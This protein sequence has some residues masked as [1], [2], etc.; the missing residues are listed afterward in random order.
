MEKGTVKWF[1]Q[2]KG[3]GFIQRENGEDI[4]FHKSDIKEEGFRSLETG[5]SVQFTIFESPRGPKAGDVSKI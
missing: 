4:F 1:N 5:D 2:R 3:Y